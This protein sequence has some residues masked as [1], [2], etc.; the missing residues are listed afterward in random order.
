MYV[1]CV[2]T[3]CMCVHA[4]AHGHVFWYMHMCAMCLCMHVCLCVC[5]GVCTACVYVDERGIQSCP[6]PLE[7]SH[8]AQRAVRMTPVMQLPALSSW[9]TAGLWLPRVHC[10][11]VI[12][13]PLVNLPSPLP[14]S[15][16]MNIPEMQRPGLHSHTYPS[17]D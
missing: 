13:P 2:W 12:H 6:A 16:P 11:S 9:I 3:V 15:Q 1:L 17:R 8:G 7:G 14:R 10:F 5:V 4:C